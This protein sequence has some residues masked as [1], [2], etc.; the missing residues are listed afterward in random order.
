MEMSDWLQKA[1]QTIDQMDVEGF[2]GFLTDDAMFRYGS[3]DPVRGKD[4]IRSA[5]AGFFGSI[6]GLRHQLFDVWEINDAVICQGEVTYTRK[7][8]KQVTLPFVD[9][10]RMDDGRV[11]EYLIY[12]DPGPL[13]T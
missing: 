2:V 5:V 9:L 4:N 10:F 6:K 8:D 11:R 13:F 1:F 12:I 3:A 7:D